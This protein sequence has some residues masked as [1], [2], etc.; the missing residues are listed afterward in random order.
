MINS[1][2]KIIRKLGE[3]RSNV[4]LCSLWDYPRIEFAI[5]ILSHARDVEEKKS[6]EEEFRLLS[7]LN[8]PNI[9]S[10]YEFGTVLSLDRDDKE[11]DISINDLFFVLE[12]FDGID[13]DKYTKLDDNNKM[14]QVIWQIM[15]VLYYLHQSNYIYYDLKAENILIK[16]NKDKLQIM[17]IDFGMARYIPLIEE[18]YVRGSKE[19]IAPEILQ[20]HT[21]DHRAD[22]YSF[23]ILLYRLIYGKFPFAEEN[24][25]EIYK[26]H[27]EQE[28]E[29]PE[30]DFSKNIINSIKK[31]LAKNPSE[32]YFNTLHMIDDLN[33]EVDLESKSAWKGKF[34]LEGRSEELHLLQKYIKSP[35]EGK[36][37]N[38]TGFDGI[39]K[40]TLLKEFAKSSDN[41][42]Y[43]SFSEYGGNFKFW[44]YFIYKIIFTEHIFRNTDSS[45]VQYVLSHL[46]DKFEVLLNDLKSISSRLSI[47]NDFILVIDDFNLLDELSQEIITQLLPIFQ[48]NNIH[49]I[50]SEDKNFSRQSEFIH[51]LNDIELKEFTE[52]N[53]KSLVDD[54]FSAFFPR[55]NLFKLIL[56]YSDRSPGNIV[57][58]VGDLILSEILDFNSE[59]PYINIDDDLID[60]LSKNLDKFSENKIKS[61]SEEELQLAQTLSAINIG[62]D[63]HLIRNLLDWDEVQ[64]N[65]SYN[66]LLERNIVNRMTANSLMQITSKRLK[67]YIYNSISDKPGF[68]KELGNKMTGLHSEIELTEI[69]RHFELGEDFSQSY[70][71]L[72]EEMVRADR[73]SAFSYKKLLLNRVLNYPLE[74]NIINSQTFELAKVCI[75]LGQYQEALDILSNFKVDHT[76]D[77]WKIEFQMAHA[78]SLMGIGEYEKALATL[79]KLISQEIEEK[80]KN[81]LMV[82]I[83]TAKYAM[84]EF[85]EVK[86]ICTNSISQSKIEPEYLAQSYNLLGLVELQSNNNPRGA[87][88]YF[89]SAIKVYK[90]ANLQVK[91]AGIELNIGNV[92]NIL[93]ERTS[94]EK[95]WKTALQINQS[96]GNIEKEAQVLLSYG[97]LF[98]EKLEFEEAIENYNRAHSIFLGLGNKAGLGMVLTNLGE[99]NSLICEY[100]EAIDKLKKAQEIFKEIKNKNEESESMFL[101]AKLYFNIGYFDAFVKLVDK[102]QDKFSGKNGNERNKINLSYLKNMYSIIVDDKDTD[103]AKLSEISGKYLQQEDTLNYVNSKLFLCESLVKQLKYEDALNCINEIEFQKNI[104]H[105][106]Y[107]LAY[108]NYILGLISKGYHESNLE[109][110]ITYFN[111]ALD[112]ISE[113][114]I[115]ELTW[116]ILYEIG[117]YYYSRGNLLKSKNYIIYA[118]SIINFIADNLRN[119]KIK[120]IY[121]THPERMFKLNELNK[122]GNKVT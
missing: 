11:Y 27:V 104:E 62:V 74:K 106:K 9:I 50:L 67:D 118:K 97:I 46:S 5:K 13:I 119:Q 16:E 63:T 53:I 25:L 49:V 23:G 65:S 20:K 29:F 95:H 28:F 80:F 56:D 78:Q 86:A 7:E 91:V 71:L 121:L 117:I 22:L 82:E 6:F 83:A 26:A 92:Y 108:S 73:V 44:N 85:N 99:V 87:I 64:F 58:F 2:I 30:S 61:L 105:N 94:A 70:R 1:R 41:I 76:E 43:I 90:K 40:S 69:S 100:S 75:S 47:S 66:S 113:E 115:T 114:S 54:S 36:V 96:I 4:F 98:F 51:N 59:G 81:N 111:T 93:H 35:A 38:I 12:Y 88:R 21:V 89:N 42:I 18:F 52:E 39:G 112:L 116:K 57:S 122:L 79:N 24:E 72:N 3:G 31:L 84:S 107:F 101:L 8:H 120:S 17:F 19:Y 14:Q 102:Y 10:V 110:E 60:E 45:I 32:R 109:P 37:V 15:S 48:A 33:F 68:H 77:E 55:E 103:V 34:K